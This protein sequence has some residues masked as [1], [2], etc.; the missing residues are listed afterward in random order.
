M[1]SRRRILDFALTRE[2]YR[3]APSFKGR[4]ASA[5]GMIARATAVSAL[6]ETN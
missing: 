4:N 5:A 2:A 1:N 3:S 6:T